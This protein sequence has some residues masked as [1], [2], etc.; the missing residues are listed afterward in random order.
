MPNHKLPPS[1]T[2][3]GLNCLKYMCR[4]PHKEPE[5][6]LVINKNPECNEELT[7]DVDYHS[8]YAAMWSHVAQ[9]ISMAVTGRLSAGVAIEGR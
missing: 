8:K 3:A 6:S 5:Y 1:I 7:R 4:A 2:I 9:T